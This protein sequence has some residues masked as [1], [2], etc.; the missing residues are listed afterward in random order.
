MLAPDALW[1]NFSL[2]RVTQ[3]NPHTNTSWLWLLSAVVTLGLPLGLAAWKH[4]GESRRVWATLAWL[5]LVWNLGWF[6]LATQFAPRALV[7]AL[8]SQDTWAAQSLGDSHKMTRILSETSGS[9]SASG[10]SMIST[11]S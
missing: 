9:A 11:A 6:L 1:C 2:A 10:I 3:L 7:S 8:R 5:L 4:G